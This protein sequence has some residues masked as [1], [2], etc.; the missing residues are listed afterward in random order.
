[1]AVSDMPSRNV[2][3]PTTGR[4][5]IDPKQVAVWSAVSL[6]AAVAWGVLALARGEQ[7]SAVWLVAA[8]VG[9]Y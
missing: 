3:P 8:A 2:E 4:R 5:R 7:V 6:V 9:S 1:M